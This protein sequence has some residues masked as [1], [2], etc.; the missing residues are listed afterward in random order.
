MQ[1]PQVVGVL[2]TMRERERVLRIVHREWGA[3]RII[4]EEETGEISP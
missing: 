1:S 3:D 2:G 4:I